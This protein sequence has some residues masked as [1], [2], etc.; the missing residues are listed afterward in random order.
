VDFGYSNEP[1]GTSWHHWK[2][3]QLTNTL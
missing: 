1:A 3:H 2:Y